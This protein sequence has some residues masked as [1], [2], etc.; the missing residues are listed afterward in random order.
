[1]FKKLNRPLKCKAD[2]L[3]DVDIGKAIWTAGNKVG[4][5]LMGQL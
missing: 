4:I 1:M 3:D 2:L 5:L